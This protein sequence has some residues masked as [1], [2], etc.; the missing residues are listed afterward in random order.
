[1]TYHDLVYFAQTW[2]L[3]YMMV[4]FAGAVVYALWPANKRRFDR[5][6]QQPLDEDN[7]PWR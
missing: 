4:I 2:G 7:G 5:A 3:I 6:A 1:M